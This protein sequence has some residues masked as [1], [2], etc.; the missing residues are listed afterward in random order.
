M[1]VERAS[2]QQNQ[3]IYAFGIST[4]D[5]DACLIILKIKGFDPAAVWR[6]R[7]QAIYNTDYTSASFT[8]SSC[9]NIESE[10]LCTCGHCHHHCRIYSRGAC[11]YPLK[12]RCPLANRRATTK[13]LI[14]SDVAEASLTWSQTRHEPRSRRT[15]FSWAGSG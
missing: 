5:A 9:K 6:P 4:S 1:R 2:R 3:Q 13:C 11:R 8:H 15:D 10:V 14:S 12:L 7:H